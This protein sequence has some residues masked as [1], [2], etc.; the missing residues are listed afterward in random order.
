M[1]E[2]NNICKCFENKYSTDKN[3]NSSWISALPKALLHEKI[4]CIGEGNQYQPVKNPSENILNEV[5]RSM[6]SSQLQTS[7]CPVK[8]HTDSWPFLDH[9]P[10]EEFCNYQ[11]KR[12]DQSEKFKACL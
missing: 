9:R 12:K 4:Y 5:W 8:G 3:S 11:Q 2:E 7:N 1:K 10:V 6:A